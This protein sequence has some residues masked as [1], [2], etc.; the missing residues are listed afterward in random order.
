MASLQIQS[1]PPKVT[2]IIGLDIHP[3][4]P[5]VWL[6]I[7]DVEY[8]AACRKK[9]DESWMRELQRKQGKEKELSYCH[10]SLSL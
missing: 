4:W 7:W 1:Q 2:R 5:Y 8:G 10:K 9:Y 6:G 3:Y